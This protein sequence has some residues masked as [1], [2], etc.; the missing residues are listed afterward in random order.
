MAANGQEPSAT[1]PW[2]R[3]V[4]TEVRLRLHPRWMGGGNVAAVRD[5]GVG[6]K[7]ACQLGKDQLRWLLVHSTVDQLRA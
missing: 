7:I 3:D 5:F 2:T 6:I 1:R 4:M